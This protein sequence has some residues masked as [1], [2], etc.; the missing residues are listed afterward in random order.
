MGMAQRVVIRPGLL[1]R[2]KRNSGVADDESFARLIGTSR[3]TLNRVRA[4]EA[5][6]MGF[7]AGIVTAFGLGFGEV[8]VL[9]EDDAE[10]AS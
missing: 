10:V 3:A 4:G 9:A 2:L 7:A 8:V 1:D 6:S 5:P